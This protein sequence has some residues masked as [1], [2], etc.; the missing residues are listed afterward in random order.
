M[1]KNEEVIGRVKE[2][3]MDMLERRIDAEVNN[4]L[5]RGR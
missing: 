2:A 1:I 3:A 4:I 5:Q